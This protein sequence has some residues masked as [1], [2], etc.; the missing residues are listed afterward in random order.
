MRQFAIGFLLGLLIFAAVNLFA[1]HVSSDCGLP[2]V[3]GRDACADDIARAGWPLQFY[4]EG[5]FAYHSNF[6]MLSLLLDTS[7]G[8]AFSALTGWFYARRKKTLSK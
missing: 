7:A 5:G 3:F 8:V 6:N 4:E 2:A 1:A